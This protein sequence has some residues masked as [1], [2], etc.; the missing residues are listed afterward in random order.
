MTVYYSIN[1]FLEWAKLICDL[2][3]NLNT[4]CSGSGYGKRFM[5]K[6]R[7]GTFQYDGNVPY[8]DRGLNC[9]NVHICH[10]TLA[11]TI[12]MYAFHFMQILPQNEENYKQILNSN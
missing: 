12:K 7:E 9:T 5:G 11:G 10:N 1:K 2:K 4:S 3:K 8:L 6:G